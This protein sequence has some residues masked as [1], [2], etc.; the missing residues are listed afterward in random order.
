MAQKIVTLTSDYGLNDPYLA[1]LKGALAGEEGD[2][3]VV[4][5][6]H[7]I[8]P[9]H[10]MEAAYILRHSYTAFPENTVHLVALEELAPS[11][12][13]LAARLGGQYFLTAD[14]G[15]LTM[16]HPELKLKQVIAIDFGQE[17]SNFPARDVLVKAAAHL[18]RG[19]KLGVLGRNARSIEQKSWPRARLLEDRSALQGNIV[20]IDHF[21]NL[22]S[23]ISRQ[24][25]EEARKQRGFS[26]LLPRN[27]RLGQI[28]DHYRA[29]APGGL[30]ALFNTHG[31]LEIGV[32]QAQGKVFNGANTLLGIKEQDLISIEFS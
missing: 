32:S 8:R 26:I 12:K 29:A 7:Q 10:L 15:L 21:G 31:L 13:M 27:R 28:S 17:A 1:A 25:F 14:S 16:I 19:G 18:V 23:N 11:G 2:F 9:G 20:Y 5:I 6:S 22:V 30:L 3:A 24:Q 4:D